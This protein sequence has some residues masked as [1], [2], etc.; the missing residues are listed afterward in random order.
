MCGL[1]SQNG[2]DQESPPWTQLAATFHQQQRGKQ[3]RPRSP[4]R[5][6]SLNQPRNWHRERQK[7]QSSSQDMKENSQVRHQRSKESFHSGYSV[8]L[9]ADSKTLQ[10]TSP[11]LR[12]ATSA[13]SAVCATST[14]L[15]SK[16]P[17]IRPRSK[18]CLCASSAAYANSVSCS[19][20]SVR[21]PF[22][23]CISSSFQ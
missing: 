21:D 6:K 9:P 12:P 8:L 10:M 18:Y 23:Y 11:D 19:S 3:H 13:A 16:M 4:G 5:E 17:C 15:S 7:F 22:F 1:H 20:V 14:L 2:A